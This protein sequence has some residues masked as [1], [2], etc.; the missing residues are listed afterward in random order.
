MS[1][2]AEKYAPY[3][4]GIIA[5]WIW[6]VAG[7]SMPKSD[8]VLGSALTIASILTGFLSTAKAILMSLDTPIM[9]RLR[10]QKY[11]D[12]L[13]SYMSE[14]IWMSFGFAL[15][16][17]IGYFCMGASIYGQL[18]IAIGVASSATFMR[19]TNIMLKILRRSHEDVG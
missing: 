5:A 16:C 8:A 12:D 9:G 11:Y 13:V 10:S 2:L 6:T 4:L 18:W 19:V 14:A 15:T 3:V 7:V 1:L 17:L